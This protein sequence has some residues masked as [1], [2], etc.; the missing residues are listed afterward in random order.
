VSKIR[1]HIRTN[2][3]VKK[4]ERRKGKENERAAMMK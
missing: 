2:E 3:K 1:W 4:E